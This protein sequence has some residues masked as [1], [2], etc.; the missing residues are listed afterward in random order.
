MI[1]K[2]RTDVIVTPWEQVL[3]FAIHLLIVHV[4]GVILSLSRSHCSMCCRIKMKGSFHSQEPT[5]Q[6]MKVFIYWVFLL[7]LFTW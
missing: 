1:N 3:S 2:K 7:F 5:I 4:G 6:I